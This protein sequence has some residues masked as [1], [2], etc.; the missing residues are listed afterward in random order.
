[1]KVLFKKSLKFTLILLP[2]III[3]CLSVT[4]WGMEGLSDEA[5][6]EIAAIYG[7][8][9]VAVVLSIL[10]NLFIAIIC[11]FF[12]YVIAMKVR[13]IRPLKLEKKP[14]II[15]LI[16]AVIGGVVILALDILFPLIITMPDIPNAEDATAALLTPMAWVA[17]LLYGGIVE[18]LMLR[19][20]VMSLIALIIWKL[21]FRKYDN[22][23]I[24]VI[25][26]VIANILAAFLF[27]VG[28]LPTLFASFDVITT[29][30]VVRTILLNMIGGLI[31]GELYRKYGLQ[32][33]I[34]AHAGFHVV[35][36]SILL[37][38]S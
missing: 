28:H 6:S 4:I 21:F 16:W 22:E 34:I 2:I 25:V 20:F 37:I 23:S 35:M 38:M 12:G 14:L 33:A 32:Y 31:F 19:L 13:L 15:T 10:P 3:A 29:G 26:F 18:E 7:S 5:R 27:G 8:F 17:A 11:T 30:F 36:K 1:M 24:P 9:A